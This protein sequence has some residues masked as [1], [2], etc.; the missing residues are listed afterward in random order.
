MKTIWKIKSDDRKTE[1]LIFKEKYMCT[2]VLGSHENHDEMLQKMTFKDVEPIRYQ[3]IKEIILNES[4]NELTV[5]WVFNEDQEKEIHIPNEIISEIK[6]LI[7]SKIKKVSIKDY[8][9]LKQLI[10]VLML[11]L[12]IIGLTAIVYIIAL[13]IENGVEAEIK[14][15]ATLIKRLALAA[16]SILGSKGTIILG[17][18]LSLLASYLLYKTYKNPKKG[19]V[20][21]FSKESTLIFN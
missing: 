11:L 7:C 17:S 10:P 20:V 18:L 16:A 8:S 14:G 15:R 19:V 21:K 5:K 6:T 3:D 12:I 1:Y 4:D 9:V 2:Y 13:D